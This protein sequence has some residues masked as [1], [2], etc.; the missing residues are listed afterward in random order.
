M[1]RLVLSQHLSFVA[2]GFISSITGPI[3]PAVRREIPM[4]YG[5]TG[6]LL[7]GLCLGMVL[8]VPIIGYLS[9]KYG[10]KP[11]L[12]IG[13][14]LLACGLLGC[15][16]SRSFRSLMI[17]N[18]IVG[19]GFGGFVVG[20]N[21]LCSSMSVS[22]KGTAMSLLHFFF[23]LGAIAGPFIVTVCLSFFQNWRMVYGVTVF[24]AVIVTLALYPL[25]FPKENEGELERSSLPYRDV[26]LWICAAFILVYGGIEI[27]FQGWIAAFWVRIAPGND[28]PASLIASVF[29]IALTIGRLFS[30]KLADRFGL[31][32]Y[33][34]IT[35]L[36]C[37][38]TT[39]TWSTYTSSWSTLGATLILGLLLAGIFP[40]LMV[41]ATSRYSGMSG[42][43]TAFISFFSSLGGLFVPPS[44]GRIADWVGIA[45][46]PV[47]VFG[48]AF[49]MLFLAI[50][51]ARFERV[52][53][54]DSLKQM[55]SNPI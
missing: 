41:S 22:G 37:A 43:V 34:I 24:L 12:I 52:H 31:S 54:D 48:L 14:I 5:E 10:K 21:A 40:T 32:R 33:L 16:V 27:S 47:I 11:L 44:I 39:L 9:D 18:I 26:F 3:L 17:W 53:I 20:I 19:I 50:W 23:G 49:L 1:K 46:L 28:L 38:V 8:T 36:G 45:K 51:K 7:A 2:I 55:T 13:G 25:K 35:S 42:V 4:T 15:M 30:G 29:W 6:L